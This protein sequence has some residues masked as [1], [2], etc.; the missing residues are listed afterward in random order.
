[1]TQHIGELE[2]QS[3]PIAGGGEVIILNTGAVIDAEASAMLQALHSRSTGG[4]RN[5]LEILGKRGSDN[6]MK[7]FYVGYGHKSI[8]DCGNAIIFIEGVSML[9]AKAIQDW[10][11]YS[12]QEASTRYVDFQTQPFS[13]PLGTEEGSAILENWRAFYQRSMRPTVE[14]LTRLYPITEGENPSIYQKAINARAFDVL[15]GFLPAGAT[16]NLAWST[17][18]RQAADKIMLLRRHPLKEVRATADAIEQALQK[19]FPN[20][21]G[22]KQYEATETYNT[23]IMENDYYHHDVNCP[24]FELKN[25]SIQ[26][27][28]LP[29]ESLAKRP[30]KTELPRHLS[31][32]GT[33]Q[34]EFLLDFG[35]FRDL[36]RH[37]AVT[38]RMPL[39]TMDIGF[40]PWYFSELPEEVVVDAKKTLADQANL[41]NKLT[42]SPEEKQYYIAMGYR[43]ANR[44]TG[45]LPALVYLVELRATRFVHPTLRKR[46][47]QMADTLTDLFSKDGLVIHLDTEIDRFDSK[48]G[49]HDIILK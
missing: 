28:L 32:A 9:T 16:T 10:P 39:L 4:L 49:E 37:R 42:I 6:F 26:T 45:N 8:G 11:L 30:A 2:H 33:V 14:H 1:M 24:E 29:H 12:G 40:E 23:Y 41:I 36:Q 46:A 19:A 18:L 17:N 7:N 15:R 21:F 43:T 31:E 27:K 34:F 48:R 44:L 3:A 38:Q 22:H 20:S 13:N 5:H 35:S 25:N 47:K